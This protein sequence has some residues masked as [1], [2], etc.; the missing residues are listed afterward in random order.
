MVNNN[1]RKTAVFLV[2]A[3][4][5]FTGCGNGNGPDPDTGEK[6]ITIK[7]L[8]SF[9]GKVVYIGLFAHA[10]NIGS[11][12]QPA[13]LGGSYI[14]NGMVTVGLYNSPDNTRWNGIGSWY[15]RLTIATDPSLIYI[16]KAAVNFTFNANPSTNF[17]NYKAYVYH[18]T[19][20]E[21]ADQMMIN[22][23]A[24]GITV[25]AWCNER[26]G[27]TYAQLLETIPGPLYKDGE[28]TKPFSGS[29]RVY[30]AT[31]IY[32]DFDIMGADSRGDKLGEIT[33]T[34]T[35]T[36]IPSPAPRVYISV[37]GENV[38]G[39]RWWSGNSRV[40]FS[41]TGTQTNIS[42]SIPVYEND[43]F[44]PSNGRFRLYVLPLGS[45]AR[46]ELI[47]PA[48]PRI[49]NVNADA[50]SLGTVSIKYITLNG[51]VNAT[52]GGQPVPAYRISAHDEDGWLD[53]ASVVS[54]GANASWTV[55]IKPFTTPTKIIFYVVG[56]P[57]NEMNWDEELFDE[58]FEPDQTASVTNQNVAGITINI[59]DMADNPTPLTA[60]IWEDGDITNSGDV[61]WYSFNVTNGTEY[62]LWW[63]DAWRGDFTKTLDIDVYVL[64]NNAALI[65]S[66][67]D[68]AWDEPFSF[69][70]NTSGTVYVRV[71]AY[72][73]G[74][75]GT[76][77]L[78]YNTTGTRP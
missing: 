49:D 35:L 38:S 47:I 14:E 44:V 76:Y 31:V 61:D 55:Y 12:V 17:S 1:R 37:S 54:A 73:E 6:S 42:W 45:S 41:G 70:A 39:H 53:S 36:D 30:A 71:R 10:N 28:L 21:L 8:N 78:A 62:Y 75:T 46:I 59:G 50:G 22:I 64:Y 9:E 7:G 15:V 25:D 4:M 77:A 58:Y 2:A 51:T 20:G 68:N 40:Q 23:P 24:G 65:N 57:N 29:D 33:G 60:N 3:V 18:Y 16:S 5:V 19:F 69:T 48:I 27:K 67:H 43:N 52:I 66:A 26:W 34:I 32:C 63:N 11:T 72:Y 56:F 74:E 13:I